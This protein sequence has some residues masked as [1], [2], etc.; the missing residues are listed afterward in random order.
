MIR[1]IDLRGQIVDDGDLPEDERSTDFAFF[2]TI[3]DT[4]QRI[5]GHQVWGDSAEFVECYERDPQGPTRPLDR[6][7]S[8]MPEWVLPKASATKPTPSAREGL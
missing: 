7:L 4:F 6:F 1:F 5:G 8:L 2:D 3:T